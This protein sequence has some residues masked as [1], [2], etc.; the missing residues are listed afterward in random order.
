MELLLS[1]N[2]CNSST[3]NTEIHDVNIVPTKGN[4]YPISDLATTRLSNNHKYF[5]VVIS[6]MQEPIT[7]KQ[8]STYPNWQHAM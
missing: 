1:L 3:V 7:Y 2:T 5:I 8:V 4:H 6:Q